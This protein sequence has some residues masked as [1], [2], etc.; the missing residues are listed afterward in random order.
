[1]PSPPDEHE[2][3][4]YVRRHVVVLTTASI[5]AFSF[6]AVSM[7]KFSLQAPATLVYLIPIA[8]IVG[9]FLVSQLSNGFSRSFDIAAHERLVSGW[10]PSAF[11][12][13]DVFLPTC[14]ED[15]EMLRATAM[16]VSA[17]RFSGPI[18]VY[19]LD[20]ANRPEVAAL[21]AEYGFT[22]L[23]RPN[24][25]WY[26][27]AGNL[28]YG[29]ERSSG[30]F[31]VVFDADFCPRPDF[32]T[33]LLPYFGAEPDLG[34]VQS[35]QF[36]RV[37]RE[38]NW[39]ERGAGAVQESFYRLA[40]MSRQARGAAIC[41][42]TNA[43]YRRVALDANGGGTLIE[44]S[45]D[46]HTG[47][48]LFRHG[49][50]LRYVP[51]SLAAGVCP[52]TIPAFLAQQY[53]WCTGSMSLLGSAKFWRTKLTIRAR[54]CYLSGFLYYVETAFLTVLGPLVPLTMIYAFPQNVRLANYLLLLPAM[55]YAFVVF[56]L[57]HRCRYRGAAW[58]TK[59]IYGWA[60]LFAIADRLRRRT[61]PWSA[62]FGRRAT[63]HTN[64]YRRFKVGVVGWSG[65]TALAWLGGSV[66]R[67]V[68]RADPVAWIPMIALG[69]VYA[70][71]AGRIIVSLRQPRETEVIVRNLVRR[72]GDLLPTMPR[73]QPRG[74]RIPR[75]RARGSVEMLS[76]S[77]VD[78]FRETAEFENELAEVLV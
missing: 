26:K 58:P 22:Y 62:T 65:G 50:R 7:V 59:M 2:R 1:M 32:L 66:W 41:V 9:H 14:G 24:R 31:I 42:G 35:P 55:V 36:F 63:E 40:Q 4:W 44:H 12:S 20:D 49:W 52:S 67:L 71:S 73:S 19:S 15:L 45:E 23:S 77:T 57:W 47:F 33:E 68:A 18:T 6:M 29:Y 10:N 72:E 16:H 61:L 39:I 70:L 51:V 5:V 27:K 56:P 17:L 21:A 11:P 25:G 76:W 64:R 13:V 34:I 48:D 78:V 75:P 30:D 8:F 53:R 54:L 43:I 3:Y 38:M 60:H 28:R 69:C 46:V 74:L 37:E